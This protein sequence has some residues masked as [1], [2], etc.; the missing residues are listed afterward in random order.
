MGNGSSKYSSRHYDYR[1]FTGPVIPPPSQM[2]HAN[3]YTSG[4]TLPSYDMPRRRR[5]KWYQFGAGRDRHR[6]QDIWYS[7][8]V[9]PR[10]QQPPAQNPFG[11]FFVF[12]L[13]L[14]TEKL[15]PDHTNTVRSACHPMQRLTR[16]LLIVSGTPRCRCR[17]TTEAFTF[18]TGIYLRRSTRPSFH[19][20]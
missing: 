10:G 3:S 7:A 8:Y 16:G 12:H 20:T 6:G 15:I 9:S 13:I 18:R 1:P 17:C 11:Q 4:S 2:T 19:K 5:R 14:T